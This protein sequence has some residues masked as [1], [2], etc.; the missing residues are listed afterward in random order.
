MAAN[1]DAL[2]AAFG[3]LATVPAEVAELRALV[4][5]LGDQ[6]ARIEQRLP[7]VLLSPDEAA[8]ALGI[9]RSTLNSVRPS[10]AI[11][12]GYIGDG[13]QAGS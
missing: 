4:T 1:P 2:G 11:A 6:L 9:S 10:V 8:K 13:A 7:P 5:G 12:S 3:A